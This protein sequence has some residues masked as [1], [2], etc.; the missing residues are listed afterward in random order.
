MKKKN[1]N[2]ENMYSAF[3]AD[4]YAEISTYDESKIEMFQKI[5]KDLGI[6]EIPEGVSNYMAYFLDHIYENDTADVLVRMMNVGDDGYGFDYDIDVFFTEFE[7]G[8]WFDDNEEHEIM[9]ETYGE[10]GY[11]LYQIVTKNFQHNFRDMA[12]FSN[13][14]SYD[15]SESI[16]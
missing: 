2:R 15:C 10:E 4:S 14:L 8:D 16:E 11:N 12:P 9:E 1:E 3:Y 5:Q 6:D 7:E 13:G